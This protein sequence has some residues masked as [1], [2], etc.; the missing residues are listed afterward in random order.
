MFSIPVLLTLLSTNSKAQDFITRGKIE[1]EVKTNNKLMSVEEDDDDEQ[2]F[3]TQIPAFTIHYQDFIFSGNQMIYKKGRKGN[4]AFAPE[5]SVFTNLN[6]GEVIRQTWE[7][8]KNFFVYR[9]STKKIKWK[10]QNE[11]RKIAGFECRKAVGRIYDSVYVVA[12]YSAEIIPQGGPELFSGLP[13][14]ILGLAIPRWHTTWFATKIEIAQVDESVIQAPAGKKGKIYSKSEM[15][16]L[17]LEKHKKDG[18][19]DITL[20][21]V[22]IMLSSFNNGSF[23]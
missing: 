15:A 9:D 4:N 16:A 8:E 2:I 22:M 10:I 11:I 5:G 14:M 20:D 19:D 13:G 1:F 6:S 17:L 12:F 7:D 18:W 3:S 23:E 21:K